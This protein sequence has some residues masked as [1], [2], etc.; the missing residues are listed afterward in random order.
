MRF[1][2]IYT[3]LIRAKKSNKILYTLRNAPSQSLANAIEVPGLEPELEYNE[4]VSACCKQFNVTPPDHNFI[5]G[6]LS[7]I[8]ERRPLVVELIIAMRRTTSNYAEAM[9]L[10]Q[11]GAGDDVRAYVFQREWMALPTD[12]FSRNILAVMALHGDPLTFGD[13]ANLSRYDE[14]RVR[15]ALSAVR[16]MFLKLNEVGSET[17]FELGALTRAFVTGQ[18]QKLSHYD[19]IRERV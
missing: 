12:N 1:D 5:N 4:F 13:L 18:A 6:E 11:Q 14:G 17:T 7:A 3:L 8:S 15:D 19:S 9:K 10:F 16:E 2:Y